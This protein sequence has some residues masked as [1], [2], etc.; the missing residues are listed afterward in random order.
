MLDEETQKIH[1]F[2]RERADPKLIMELE[3]ARMAGNI[4]RYTDIKN[5][6]IEQYRQSERS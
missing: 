1:N 6:L 4:E 5:E 2:I 3:E